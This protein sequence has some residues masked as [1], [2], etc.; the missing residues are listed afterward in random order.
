M[1]IYDMT[2]VPKN[3]HEEHSSFSEEKIIHEPPFRADESAKGKSSLLSSFLARLFFAALLLLDV[4]W[5]S[6]SLILFILGLVGRILTFNRVARF[7][8]WQNKRWLAFKRSL[9]CGLALL[10]AIFNP[11]FGIMIACTYF[12]MYDK[13]GIEEVIPASLQDQ[14][15]EFF[16]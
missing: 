1:P 15:R 9:V 16:K 6:Y 13:N 3:P 10:A 8:R 4:L 2:G 14:F 11:A 5:A 12:L 7:S